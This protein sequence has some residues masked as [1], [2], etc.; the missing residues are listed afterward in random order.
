M[1]RF[2]VMYFPTSGRAEIARAILDYA[3]V[4]YKSIYATQ[5]PAEKGQ[6]PYGQL[7]VLKEYESDS[8]E[9]KFVLS[10]SDAIQRYLGA[11]YG[12]YGTSPAELQT[13]AQQDEVLGQWKDVTEIF[14]N[15]IFFAETEEEKANY[16]L[17]LGKAATH[18]LQKH[19]ERL[20]RNGTG[21][22]VGNKTTLADLFAYLCLKKLATMPNYKDTLEEHV[23][24]GLRKFQA[25]LEQDP[26]FKRYQER[27]V[28]RYATYK[29]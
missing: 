28:A 10:D 23:G 24:K 5:W 14:I 13:N 18:L 12:L 20:L 8:T 17:K 16:L 1:T 21:H 9:P 19:D 27:A 15:Y 29:Y 11:R 3:D 6:T 4:E 7:P 22:Y 2:E 25:T 26:S